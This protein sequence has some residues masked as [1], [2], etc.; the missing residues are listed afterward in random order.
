VADG[1]RRQRA[2]L[3]FGGDERLRWAAEEGHHGGELV[4][5]VAGPVD[6]EP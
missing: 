6:V 3:T 4:G 1:D 5:Q 2:S